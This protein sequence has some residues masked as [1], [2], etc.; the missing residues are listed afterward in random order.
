MHHLARGVVIE[1]DVAPELFESLRGGLFELLVDFGR[2]NV[3]T[4]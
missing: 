2:A 3:G 4:C 1:V